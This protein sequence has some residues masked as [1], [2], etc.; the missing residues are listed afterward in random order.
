MPGLSQLP[1]PPPRSSPLRE[2]ISSD[3]LH[4]SGDQ[5]F[6]QLLL[7]FLARF[8]FLI[9][10]AQPLP[11]HLPGSAAF[12]HRAI[13]APHRTAPRPTRGVSALPRG[14][15]R[16]ARV[17]SGGSPPS[18]S[19]GCAS[20]PGGCEAGGARE[21]SRRR[22]SPRRARCC[23][24]AP[25][26]SRPAPPNGAAPAPGPPRPAPSRPDGRSA[27]PHGGAAG[28]VAAGGRAGGCG[29]TPASLPRSDPARRRRAPGSAA[30]L[31]LP[32]P[33]PRCAVRGGLRGGV[34]GRCCRTTAAWRWWRAVRRRGTRLRCCGGCAGR[35]W[36][37]A[38][39]RCWP[40]PDP[41]ASCSRSTSSPRRCA[42]PSS[43]S[44]AAAALRRSALR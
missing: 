2:L 32:R 34:P 33:R 22:R 44:S 19:R 40:C 31:R 14:G 30:A 27:G 17:G 39:R 28:A 20:P 36:G 29:G 23:G 43:A 37:A 4:L 21:A 9:N 12:W 35:C 38:W 1:P 42:F 15:S 5:Y 18:D 6:C 41:A 26:P 7:G 8:L 10:V 11:P 24:A 3:S 25:V 16:M 13:L